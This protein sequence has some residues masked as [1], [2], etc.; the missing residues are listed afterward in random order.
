MFKFRREDV[1]SWSN[2]DQAEK[3]L[4]KN[5]LFAKY[6]SEDGDNWEYGTLFKY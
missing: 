3:Y 5:G 1:I 6:Y 4:D 2:A